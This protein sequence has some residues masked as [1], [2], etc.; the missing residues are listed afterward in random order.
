MSKNDAGTHALK[1]HI[2][3]LLCLIKSHALYYFLFFFCYF[4]FGVLLLY[5][6]KTFIIMVKKKLTFQK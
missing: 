5:L 2:K 6:P 3:Y 1:K 4:T